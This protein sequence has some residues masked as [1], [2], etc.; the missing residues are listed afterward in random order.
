MLRLYLYARVRV[1]CTYCTRDRG[2]SKHPA[3][4]APSIGR[5]IFQGLG[6]IAPRDREVVSVTREVVSVTI[7]TSLRGAKRRLVR[8]SSTS[9]GGSNPFLLYA[10]RWIA[11]RSLS[12]G[13]H[14]RDP[15]ARNEDKSRHTLA[16]PPRAAPRAWLF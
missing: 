6:R 1:L 4:P 16:T 10:A 13:A 11:S 2:C 3:F 14:S 12:S 9:E 15:V 5:E 7:A 8:R